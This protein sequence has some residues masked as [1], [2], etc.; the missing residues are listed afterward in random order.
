MQLPL[1]LFLS[2]PS[3]E[4]PDGDKTQ[5]QPSQ[6]V[7]PLGVGTERHI[8]SDPL[9]LGSFTL[10]EI[11]YPFSVCVCVCVVYLLMTKGVFSVLSLL[12]WKF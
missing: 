12:F 4:W 1:A 3:Y 6:E 5:Q 2:S 9:S 10:C 11:I 7:Q 8:L